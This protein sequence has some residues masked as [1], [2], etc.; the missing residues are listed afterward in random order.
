VTRQLALVGQRQPAVPDH[1]PAVHQYVGDVL[2]V[3]AVHARLHGVGQRAHGRSRAQRDQV[4]VVA[5]A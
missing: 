4:G 1:E 5:G 2:S 3:P